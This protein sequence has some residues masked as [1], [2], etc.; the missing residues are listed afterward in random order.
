MIKVL[1]HLKIITEDYSESSDV[2]NWRYDNS[3][4]THY[5]A[6]TFTSLLRK[7]LKSLNDDF[8]YKLVR[9]IAN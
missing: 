7:E 6:M 2:K 4:H 5:I 9:F 1:I 3:A 8:Y